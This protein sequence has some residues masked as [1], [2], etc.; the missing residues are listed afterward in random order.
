VFVERARGRLGDA[1]ECDTVVGPYRTWSIAVS[2]RHEG[3]ELGRVG[4]L[5]ADQEV[6]PRRG[7]PARDAGS[8]GEDR[9][10]WPEA[11]RD[12]A[13]GPETLSTD[14]IAQRIVA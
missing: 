4:R 12:A 11:H 3:G 13:L 8:D 1:Q 5:E 2:D 6:G 10:L 7:P 14:V 9:G